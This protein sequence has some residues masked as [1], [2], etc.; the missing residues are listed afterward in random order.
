MSSLV[1]SPSLAYRLVTACFDGDLPSVRAAIADG[2]SVNEAGKARGYNSVWLPLAAA[3]YYKQHAVVA[4]LLSNGADPNGACVMYQ[5]ASN[6]SPAILQALIDAGGDVNGD[7]AGEPPLF[8][9]VYNKREDNVRLLLSQPSLD[10]TRAHA[11]QTP[12]QYARATGRPVLADMIAEEVSSPGSRCFDGTTVRFVKQWCT[13]VDR[14]RDECRWYGGNW[15]VLLLAALHFRARS[16]P[17]SFV[18]S[19]FVA[20]VRCIDFFRWIGDLKSCGRRK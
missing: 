9:A 8:A 10:W 11:G 2:A 17:V 13:M 3:V 14:S 4:W 18:R 19:G 12:E 1:S 5:G 20:I 16:S 7:S 6:S 15:F